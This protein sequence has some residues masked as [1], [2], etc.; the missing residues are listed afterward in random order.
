MFIV[1][2]IVQS[3]CHILQF[4]Y[5][6]FNVSALLLDDALLKCVVTEVVL[7]VLFS[8]VAFKTS[9]ISQGSV[10]TQLRCVGIFSDSIVTNFLL[11]LRVYDIAV[12]SVC[13]SSVCL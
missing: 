6:M 4:L 5:H 1:S 10:A 12:L 2:V 13:L 9:D 7:F 8:I 3:N 11:I